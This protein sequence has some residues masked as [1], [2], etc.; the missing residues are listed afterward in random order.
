MVSGH[1]IF[2]CTQNDTDMLK[3]CEL[4]SL[5]TQ[6]DDAVFVYMLAQ[7]PK[8]LVCPGLAGLLTDLKKPLRTSQRLRISRLTQ[9]RLNLAECQRANALEFAY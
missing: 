9:R 2:K 5:D 1:L 3:L 6:R 8:M 7:F 4:P